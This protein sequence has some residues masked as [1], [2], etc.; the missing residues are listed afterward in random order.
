MSQD[1]ARSSGMG[2]ETVSRSNRVSV[3]AFLS[4]PATEQVVRDGLADAVS[5]GL[6]LRAAPS[7]RRSAPWRNC[8]RLKR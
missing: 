6:D 1:L 7:A 3:L 5:N 8:P 4:D 2:G